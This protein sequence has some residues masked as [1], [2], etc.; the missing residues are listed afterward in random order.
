MKS[1]IGIFL[2]AVSLYAEAEQGYELKSSHLP[3][4]Y[5]APAGIDFKEGARIYVSGSFLYWVPRESGL[6]VG[7]YDPVN[8]LA[9]PHETIEMNFDFCPGFKTALG[10]NSN[11][12]NWDACLEY[13]RFYP[14][15]TKNFSPPSWA[16]DLDD[17]YTSSPGDTHLKLNLK[18]KINLLNL[19]VGR[20]FYNGEKLIL[21]P[22][23]G[24]KGGWLNQ[25]LNATATAK[26]TGYIYISKY[27][28]KTWLIGPKLGLDSGWLLGSGFK[29]IGNGYFNLLYQKFNNTMKMEGQDDGLN[30]NTGLC[31][32][33]ITPNFD[34][35]VGLGWGHYLNKGKFHFDLSVCYEIQYYFNQSYFR[36]LYWSSLYVM[37]DDLFLN[38]ATFKVQFDF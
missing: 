6:E 37:T 30:F 12:D 32:G 26:T 33:N 10:Y 19:F 5:N 15:F 18:M 16:Q 2:L 4:G 8:R 23:I 21:K 20:N 31:P 7:Q 35:N 11:F 9:N 24:V 22:V 36:Q 25:Y 38:G 34:L 27:A 1:L 29:I 13:L 14:D 28:L 17:Y 3:A